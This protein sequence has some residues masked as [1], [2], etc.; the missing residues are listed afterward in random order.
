MTKTYKKR[1]QKRGGAG[2]IPV[3]CDYLEDKNC[4]IDDKK[5]RLKRCSNKEREKYV[6]YCCENGYTPMQWEEFITALN[7]DKPNGV[8]DFPNKHLLPKELLDLLNLL[9]DES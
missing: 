7:K 2:F 9:P 5:E 4:N 1:K 3:N 8:E 6:M